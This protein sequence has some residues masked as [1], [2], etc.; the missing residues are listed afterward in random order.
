ML[1]AIATFGNVLGAVVNRGLGM[2]ATRYRDRHGRGPGQA[3][4]AEGR[5]RKFG[6]YSL[7][8]NWVPSSAIRSP[9]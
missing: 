1:I 3:G 6:R 2:F 8:L 5:Y 7:L 9:S 4:K